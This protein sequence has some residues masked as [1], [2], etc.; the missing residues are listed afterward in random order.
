MGSTPHNSPPRKRRMHWR[1]RMLHWLLRIGC[2]CPAHAPGASTCSAC[3][4]GCP[5]HC[6]MPGVLSTL[7]G[8]GSST[9]RSLLK[10]LGGLAVVGAA[11][12]AGGGAV[13]D[14]PSALPGG[15]ARK[16]A[17]QS[18]E[19]RGGA[20]GRP[21]VNM[22]FVRQLMKIL[23]VCIPSVFSMEALWAAIAGGAEFQCPDHAK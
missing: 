22:E 23:A 12:R 4:A 11:L 8:S 18:A 19:A 16:A 7:G 10:Y 17:E 21:G 13:A 15:A 14:A 20:S 5:C 3:P 2:S 9:S 6:T 1:I